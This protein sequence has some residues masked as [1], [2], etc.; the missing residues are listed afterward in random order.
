MLSSVLLHLN[1]NRCAER[2][3]DFGVA[4]AERS[5]ARVRG[6]TLT[7]TRRLASLAS[8]SE[9]AVYVST[10]FKRLDRAEQRQLAVRFHLSQACLSAGV[11]FDVRQMRGDP[12]DVL[13]KES[14]YHDLII[15]AAG[16]TNPMGH[17]DRGT[18]LAE[19]E[20]ID[21]LLRGVQPMLVLRHRPT[22]LARVLLVYDGT[23]ASARAV[24]LFFGQALLTRAEF[25]LLTVGETADEAGGL[26]RE[27]GDYCSTRGCVMEKG[28]LRGSLRRVLAPYALK[29]EA[30]LVVLGVPNGNRI[31]RRLL[32][33]AAQDVLRKTDCA[34]YA[35]A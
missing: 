24:K 34:L 26:Y 13:P 6:M 28:T 7:D 31:V 25:R 11:N 18:G 10:A 16:T 5:E 4:L 35:T 1:G 14:H 21:L 27:M 19:R 29:W 32:G 8:A 20:L 9:S 15:T 33:E 17:E 12:F 22:N 23:A 3:V 30:D 2:V